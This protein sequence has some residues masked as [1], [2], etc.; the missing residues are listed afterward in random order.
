MK[1]KEIK[2]EKVVATK[3]IAEDGSVFWDE[4][5]CRKYE[6]S[7]LFALSQALKIKTFVKSECMIDGADGEYVRVFEI[8]TEKELEKLK[9]YLYFK[10]TEGM[11]IYRDGKWYS[12][13]D[14]ASLPRIDLSG[15]TYNHKI[16]TFWNYEDDYCWIFGDGSLEA[17]VNYAKERMEKPLQKHI[18]IMLKKLITERINDYDY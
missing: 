3:Y 12:D 10:A 7:A 11:S 14:V 5:E 6:E 2:E 9:R 15:L 18:Q 1:V 13:Y 4:E 17:Y 8:S 16:I